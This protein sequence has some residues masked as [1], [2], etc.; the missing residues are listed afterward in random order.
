MNRFIHS[1]LVMLSRW[2][3][4]YMHMKKSLYIGLPLVG[5]LLVPLVAFALSADVEAQIAALR[6]QITQIMVQIAALQKQDTPKEWCHTFNTNLRIGDRGI[7]VRAL[8]V[9]LDKEGF[10][11]AYAEGRTEPI[12]DDGVFI[13]PTASA[14]VG[15]QEKYKSKIL[16]PAGLAHGTGYVGAG[17][18][19]KLNQL[20]GCVKPIPPPPTNQIVCAQDA[21][22][23]S[24]GS[25]V[26]RTGPKCEF[27]ACPNSNDQ[28]NNTVTNWKICRDNYYNYTLKYPENWK[29]WRRGAGEFYEITTCSGLGGIFSPNIFDSKL[30]RFI[31][32]VHTPQALVKTF[33]KNDR[34]VDEYV[35]NPKFSYDKDTTFKTDIIAGEKAV[36]I[37]S[38]TST[39]IV[40]YHQG[41]FYSLIFDNL[42]TESTRT[43]LLQTFKFVR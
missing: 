39:E 11:A 26:S 10:S 22:Q 20:Y 5:L 15:F 30:P 41:M 37:V 28:S 14:V 35:Y 32:E 17:T 23:C 2:G 42:L 19:R 40:V 13:D 9:A 31:L 24:D 12:S 29:V 6:L 4:Q 8:G 7:D 38:P 25:Y 18:R 3:V 34:T 43:T 1:R 16:T 21:K 33:H 27:K 36:W